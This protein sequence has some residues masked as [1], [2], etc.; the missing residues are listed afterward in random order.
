MFKSLMTAPLLAAAILLTGPSF[1][2]SGHAHE[3]ATASS[4]QSKAPAA[5]PRK[6]Q[7]KSPGKGKDP[8]ATAADYQPGEM[9]GWSLHVH[10]DLVA[11]KALYQEVL[12]ELHH[13]LFRITKVLPKDKVELLMEV[14]VWIEHRN[15]YSGNC[16]Y[17]PSRKWLEANGYLPEKA[18]AVELSSAKGF[19]RSSRDGQPFVMLHELAHAYHD[20]HLSFDRPDVIEAYKQAKEKGSYDK[21]L[22]INGRT[23]RAYAMADHKEYFAEATEAYFGTNDHFPFVRSELKQHDPGIYAVLQEVW[24]VKR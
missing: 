16:Q 19:L 20:L 17:H 5:E 9:L 7:R 14:P 21:V 3:Q 1:A 15:P 13:Q 8:H 12:D 18:K 10:K 22:H 11:D 4:E 24:G 23:V 6:A 2:H